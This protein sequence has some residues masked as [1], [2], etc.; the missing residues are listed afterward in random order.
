MKK[1]L[2][3]VIIA[4]VMIF[5]GA[6][7][8]SAAAPDYSKWDSQAAYPRDVVNTPLFAPVK[9]LMDKKIIE[10]YPDG[11]FRPEKGVTRTEFLK[12]ILI[13]TNNDKD[14]G[15]YT[16]TKFPDAAGHWGAKYINK[17][18]SMGLIKG[19]PD[20]TFAPDAG[21][22]Y[23]Q[24]FAMFLRS[25]GISDQEMRAYGEWPDNYA[26]YANMYGML[27]DVYVANWDFPASRGDIAKILYRNLP[28]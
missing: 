5:S 4:A 22:T 21:V 3:S 19:M 15:A 10:G 27:G 9:S 8:V 28:K 18:V 16:Q 1:K 24:A 25:R 20:G 14:A 23:A 7:S 26:K 6:V 13:A 2:M 12:M 17:G 11:L